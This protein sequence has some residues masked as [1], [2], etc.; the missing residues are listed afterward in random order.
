MVFLKFITLIYLSFIIVGCAN[1]SGVKSSSHNN[2]GLQPHTFTFSD[3]GKANYY[4]F[5]LVNKKNKINTLIFFISGSGCSSVKNRFPSYFSPLTGVAAKVYVLQKR[6]I[7]DG[8]TGE[9]C[10]KNFATTD[11]FDQILKDQKEFI[12]QKLLNPSNY[13][14]IVLIGAS[15]GSTVAAKITES[16]PNITL[17]GLIGSGGA[18]LR[19]D[20]TL[21]AKKQ[22]LFRLTFKRNLKAIGREPNSLTKTAWGHSYKYWSSILD[23]DLRK[24]LPKINI[25]IV[26]GMGE[27]DESVPVDS[28]KELKQIFE[29]KSKKN[30]IIKV[31]PNADHRLFNKSNN[32]SYAPDFLLTLKSKLKL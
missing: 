18:S 6:G 16:N 19:T 1:N 9:N 11:Y 14:N 28:L 32:T 7:I 27:K 20:L 13:Q 15:E 26:I 10:S 3:Q 4:T 25:P 5:D 22:L 17:L 23:V 12:S 24:I 31:Y 21:L 29:Q 8:Q 2:S 30:L